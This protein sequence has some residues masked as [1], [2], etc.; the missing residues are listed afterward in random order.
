[1]PR[2]APATP[3]F[4]ELS[5]AESES[6]LERNHV[7]RLAFSFR[8]AVDV[9]PLHYVFDG[10]WIFGRTSPSDKLVTLRHNQW[11]AFEVDEISGPFDWASVVARGT[12]YRVENEGSVHDKRLYQRALS[13]VRKLAPQTLTEDDPTAFRTEFFGIH[14][15]SMT[16]RSSSTHKT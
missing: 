1:M 14:I 2:K 11:V 3:E 8:D 5:R 7:G 12:F 10:E 9:R 6:L 4:R 15:E 16:G 13:S